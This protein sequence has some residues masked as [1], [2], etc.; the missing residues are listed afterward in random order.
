L[1]AGAEGYGLSVILRGVAHKPV[2]TI[3]GAGNL[4]NALAPALVAAGYRIDRIL[5]RDRSSS[6]KRAQVLARRVG[7]KAAAL[8]A[9]VSAGVLWL[10]VSDDAIRPC[11]RELSRAGT[12]KGRVVLHSSGALSSDELAPL[13]R[14]GASVASLHPMMTFVP[15]A[16]V[17]MAEV[18]FAVEG[19]P[20]AVRMARR[21]VRDLKARAFTLSKRNKPLYHAFGSFS[22]PMVIATLAMAERIAAAAGVPARMR[23]EVMLPIVR[24]TFS[25]YLEGSADKAFS[26]PIARGDVN[27]IRRHLRALRKVSGAR[28]IYVALARSALKTLPVRNRRAVARILKS[29]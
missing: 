11:A 15:S 26:G 18:P 29:R 23:R 25:N 5:S 20:A 24:K 6:L 14:R 21:I 17:R 13:R 8:G 9:P 28:E 4:A 16:R 1:P 22:S 10:C 12:W 7:G 2:I 3:V 27:T 19:D